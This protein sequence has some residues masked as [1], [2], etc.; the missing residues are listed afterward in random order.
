YPKHKQVTRVQSGQSETLCPE[1]HSSSA[2]SIALSPTGAWRAEGDSNGEVELRNDSLDDDQSR[3][4][5]AH[6]GIVSALA[7]SYDETQ[8]ATGGADGSITIWNV[9]ARNKLLTLKGHT[10]KIR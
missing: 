10:E 9:K 2:Y 7:F 8:L 6:Q 4:L 1:E 3:P 5:K